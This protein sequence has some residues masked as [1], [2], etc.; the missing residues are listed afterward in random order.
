[1]LKTLPDPLCAIVDADAAVRAG[2]RPVDLATAF[3]DGGARFL[4]LRAKA[5][6]SGPLLETTAAIMALAR[7]Y[8]A[9]LIV[10]DRADIAR[11]AGAGGVHV[12]QDD[13]APAAV[14]A[15]VGPDAIVGLSTHTIEQIDR[16]VGEPVGYVAIGPVFGTATKVTGYDRVGL[17][18]VRA[19]AAR[20]SA[21]GLPLVAIGGITLET[22]ASVLAA[23][24][25]SV[26]V[27]GDL[28]AGGDPERRTREFLAAL[29]MIR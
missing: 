7:S 16:A 6:A 3:L 20:A 29:H 10:N 27:I 18:M 22:A 13:L 15:I 28:L 21:R 1:M 14:R 2:W 5:M 8:G 23:G 26:A 19:A 25:T 11:L 4:Q 12:G 9:T 17:D 24:A